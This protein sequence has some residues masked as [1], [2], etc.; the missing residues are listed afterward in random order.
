MKGY[1]NIAEHLSRL[2]ME[3]PQQP[4]LISHQGDL[5]YARLEE[6]SSRC[7]AGLRQ[8][9]IQPGMRMVVMVRPGREFL[10]LVF[11]LIK[12]HAVMVLVD[13]G[14][15]RQHLGRCLD[16]ARPEAFVGVPRAH[17]GRILFGWGGRSLR[18]LITV[19]GVR[20]WKGVTLSG[21]MRQGQ[22]AQGV[23]LPPAVPDQQ[24]ALVFTTGSTGPPKGVVYT[25]G[26]F[27]AQ[28]ELLRT[29]FDIQP[30]EIDLATFPL[31]ALFDPALG[32]T[33][34]FPKM[35]FTRPARANPLEIV[36]TIR[37]NAVTHLF[38]SPAL[39]DRVSRYGEGR[40]IRLPSLKRVLSAGAPVPHKV[41]E[42]FARML[43]PPADLHTPYGATEALPV[44]T[45][46]WRDLAAIEQTCPGGGVCVGRSLPGVTLAVITMTEEA[47]PRWADDLLVQTHQVGELVVWGPNVSAR[48]WERPEAERMSKIAGPEGEVR[49]RMGDLG[50]LDDQERV[51]FCGRKSE[52][53]VTA[54]GTLFTVPCEQIFNQHPQVFRS[55]L[56][57]IGAWPNQRPVLCV[58]VEPGSKGRPA[59]LRQELLEMAQ[60]DPQTRILKTILF[61][62]GF[63]VDVRHNA[64]IGRGQLA[65]W[66]TRELR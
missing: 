18:F 19:G 55:A 22:G 43:E 60:T 24:A 32:M 13:P 12:I 14:L 20:L 9:G 53:V 54:D 3:R 47:I 45:I 4:A 57:G 66:A 27:A 40:G 58:E 37:R 34:I 59:E 35:D 64:K 11:A 36:E 33:T 30:G 21:L 51:W 1:V 23:S 10:I 65:F 7:A 28:A 52:R 8:L 62:P 42:R 17:L 6:L 31:F 50:Y 44:S 5:S 46:A 39:L 2:A 63:P 48:Y 15:G 26:M 16:E 29:A 56:V 61:H 25:H 41:L 49:H 38:G